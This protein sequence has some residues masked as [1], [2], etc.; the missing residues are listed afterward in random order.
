MP[1][2][3]IPKPRHEVILSDPDFDPARESREE[4]ARA[5]RPPG[6]ENR[7]ENHEGDQR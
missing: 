5:S 7:E 1:R 4:Q 2:A 3:L 6:E